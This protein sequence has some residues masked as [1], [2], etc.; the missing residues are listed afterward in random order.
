MMQ[1]W[2]RPAQNVLG[3]AYPDS[4][5]A[6]RAMLGLG[7]LG[8]TA[9]VSPLAAG[10]MAGMAGLY[11]IPGFLGGLASVRPKVAPKVAGALTQA[12]PYLTSGL[13][14]ASEP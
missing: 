9:T 10:T 14:A 12:V 6:G 1:D 4:G 2:A 5:T 8:G 3:G 7:L 13:V 11:E